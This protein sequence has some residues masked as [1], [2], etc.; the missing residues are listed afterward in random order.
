MKAQH[1]KKHKLVYAYR[2]REGGSES[3]TLISH[4]TSVILFS[5]GTITVMY[6]LSAYNYIRSD[7]TF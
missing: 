5:T 3:L 7:K 2:G 6:A 1:F 4:M